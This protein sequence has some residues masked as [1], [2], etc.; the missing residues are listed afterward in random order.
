MNEEDEEQALLSYY[1]YSQDGNE[2]AAEGSLPTTG[3]V[4]EKFANAKNMIEHV[5]NDAHQAG[6]IDKDRGQSFL[7]WFC[8][9]SATAEQFIL[10][11]QPRYDTDKGFAAMAV[12]NM[13]AIALAAG[14]REPNLAFIKLRKLQQSSAAKARAAKHSDTDAKQ[15]F[16]VEQVECWL[17]QNRSRADWS[18]NAIAEE[19]LEAVNVRLTDSRL[20]PFGKA[21]SLAKHV[22]TYLET[23]TAN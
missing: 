13:V 4:N 1:K 10:G 21:N 15:A 7:N 18:G 23:R 11:S 12:L 6:L 9:H 17:R 16:I 5:L 8:R 14:S 19:I 22:R 20:A 2:H 3:F